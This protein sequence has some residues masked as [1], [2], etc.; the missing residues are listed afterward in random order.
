MIKGLKAFLRSGTPA[1]S[2]AGHSADELQVAAAAL[3]VEAATMD[4]DFGPEERAKIASLVRGRFGLTAE[5]TAEI[6][7]LAEAKVEDSVQVFGF[8]RVLKDAFDHEERVEMMEMLWQVVY[9]DGELHDMEASLM[10]RVAGLLFVSDR[11]SGDARKRA[12]RRLQA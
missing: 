2:G 8:T 3:M 6:L 1:E 9:A 12:L 4:D 10:R 7:E 5:E 11:E